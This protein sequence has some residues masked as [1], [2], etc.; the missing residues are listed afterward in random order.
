MERHSIR[1]QC[2]CQSLLTCIWLLCVWNAAA[3]AED[4]PD[5]IDRVRPSIVGIGTRQPSRVP[6]MALFGTGFVVGD[7]RHV[8]T[9]AHVV[10]KTLDSDKREDLSV[11]IGVGPSPQVRRA[12][13]TAVDS[14]H[15]LALLEFDGDPLPPVQLGPAALAREGTNLAFTGF[16]L[17]AVL[18]LYPVTH[19]AMVSAITPIVAPKDTEG[20]LTAE[21]IARLRHP[22]DVLQLDATAYPGNSGSP[23]FDRHSGKVVGVVNMVFVKE[24]RE[25]IVEKPS[26][27]AYAIPVRYV[28]DLLQQQQQRR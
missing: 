27:I 13:K 6:E 26:G 10:E 21:V 4:L 1:A 11:F 9:N 16:P 19:Q 15:D 24:T 3:Y 25:N 17:G 22:F 8:I 28:R 18:G 20:Q 5:V 12:R 23:L 2:L 7:G 14:R